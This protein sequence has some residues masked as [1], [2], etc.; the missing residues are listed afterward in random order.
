MKTSLRRSLE[1]ARH[2][3]DEALSALYHGEDVRHALNDVSQAETLLR[4]VVLPELKLRV[5]ERKP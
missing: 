4:D 2:C 1:Q 3:L 5:S